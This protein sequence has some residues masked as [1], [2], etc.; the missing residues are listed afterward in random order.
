VNASGQRWADEWGRHPPKV[1]GLASAGALAV[2]SPSGRTASEVERTARLASERQ[3]G[4]DGLMNGSLN[5]SALNQSAV[6]T[7]PR[8]RSI[9]EAWTRTMSWQEV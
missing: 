8:L 6:A 4:R 5:S 7:F 1:C 9:D 2:L 3:R